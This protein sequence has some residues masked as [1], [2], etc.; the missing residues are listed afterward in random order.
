MKP[1]Y[2][3]CCGKELKMA[4]TTTKYCNSCA[5]FTGD[6]RRENHQLRRRLKE[7]REK[8]KVLKGEKCK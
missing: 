4:F 7:V 5:V 2:C 1:K 3:E 8:L 6:L